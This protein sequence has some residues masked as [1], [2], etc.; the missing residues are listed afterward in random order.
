MPEWLMQSFSEPL[1]KAEELVVRLLVAT[2][3]GAAVA[4]LYR[5]T[6]GRHHEDP[7]TLKTT[8]VLLSILIAMVSMRSLYSVEVPCALM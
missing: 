6:H 2:V 5:I 4:L 3:Y 7:T 1:P 8:L